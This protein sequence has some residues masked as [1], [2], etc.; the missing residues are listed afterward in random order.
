MPSLLSVIKDVFFLQSGYSKCLIQLWYTSERGKGHIPR[1][2]FPG[3]PKV[4]LSIKI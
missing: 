2:L 1:G 3:G 4:L